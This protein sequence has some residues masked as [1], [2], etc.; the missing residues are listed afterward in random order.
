MT[1]N[2]T[3]TTKRCKK[4]AQ[5]EPGYSKL[6]M[7]VLIAQISANSLNPPKQPQRL[8]Q[9]PKTYALIRI[10]NYIGNSTNLKYSIVNTT[11]PGRITTFLHDKEASPYIQVKL[12]TGGLMQI[13]VTVNDTY[14]QVLGVRLDTISRSEPKFTIYIQI[15]ELTSRPTTETLDRSEMSPEAQNFDQKSQ[16]TEKFKSWQK[17]KNRILQQDSLVAVPFKDLNYLPYTV[18]SA[19]SGSAMWRIVN[20]R[21]DNSGSVFDIFTLNSGC[22]NCSYRSRIPEVN[23]EYYKDIPAYKLNIFLVQS[24]LTENR[25]NSSNMSFQVDPRQYLSST[26][27]TDPSE[28]LTIKINDIELSSEG[29]YSIVLQDHRTTVSE[30]IQGESYSAPIILASIYVVIL[31]LGQFI[32]LSFTQPQEKYFQKTAEK[33]QKKAEIDRTENEETTTTD[34]FDIMQS[35]DVNIAALDQNSKTIGAGFT[36]REFGPLSPYSR[37]RVLEMDSL[38][39]IGISMLIFYQSGAG[40]YV[41]FNP[42]VWE[43][44]TIMDLI[45]PIF[46]FSI[47]FCLQFSATNKGDAI[48]RVQLVFLR[49]VASFLLGIG[50]ENVSNNYD[51]L[52]YTGLMQRLAIAY[53]VVGLVEIICPSTKVSRRYPKKVFFLKNSFLIKTFFYAC[54]VVLWL[55]LTLLVAVPGCPTGYQGVG[56]IGDLHKY[57][58]CTGGS[59]QYIDKIALGDSHMPQYMLC[60]D[61]YLC[62]SF[63]CFGLVGTLT[64]IFSCFLGEVSGVLYRVTKHF[65]RRF[66]RLGTLWVCL[67]LSCVVL[68]L[69]DRYV[70]VGAFPVNRNLWSV[71]FVLLSSFIVLLVFLVLMVA[72]QLP[73]LNFWP[74]RELSRNSVFVIFCSRVMKGRFPFGFY[75]SGSHIKM[76]LSNLIAVSVWMMVAV[77]LDY[78]K[79]YI[80]F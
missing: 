42:S 77:C 3:K 49:A 7:T 52:R 30:D 63:D 53:L 73:H 10:A 71:G 34:D 41:I 56:G 61:V 24:I 11:I 39:G 65:G 32:Y 59:A 33:T 68:W 31:S 28:P 50:Y 78:F 16:K 69:L 46:A 35:L 18:K 8:T 79:F 17:S 66:V 80:R 45:E 21:L 54:L 64:F 14:K 22:R 67:G 13:V 74:Y 37:S 19:F 29:I 6:L 25:Q 1:K 70:F 15:G 48:K 51:F 57:Q 12:A 76:T 60:S 62:S 26:L 43:G 5:M 20:L 44:L 47:G 58:N 72:A 4:H 55:L 2:L 36:T 9:S 38:K 75:N 40:N 23:A 27:S